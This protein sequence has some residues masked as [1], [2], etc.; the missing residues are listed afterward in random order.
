MVKLISRAKYISI[1]IAVS[2]FSGLFTFLI[3]SLPGIYLNLTVIYILPVTIDVIFT[4]SLLFS[5]RKLKSK[6]KFKNII[7][8]FIMAYI[9]LESNA[10]IFSIHKIISLILLIPVDSVIMSIPIFSIFNIRKKHNDLEF[11][12]DLTSRLSYL[13]GNNAPEVYTKENLTHGFGGII[14]EN[15][16]K[17][18]VHKN[19]LDALNEKE[20]DALLLELYYKKATKMSDKIVLFTFSF[21]AFLF[22]LYISSF[23]VSMNVS[24]IYFPYLIGITIGSLILLFI[25]PVFILKIISKGYISV[26]KEILLHNIDKN[27]LISLI[28]KENN[29]EPYTAMT[30]GQYNRFKE[31]QKKNAKRRIENID[32]V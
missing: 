6:N 5:M 28:N 9:L 3:F 30:P 19:A 24:S 31:K 20:L 21:I 11:N 18:V 32:K 2:L 17:I 29:Y 8:I 25:S 13:I 26:D 10:M 12:A 4:L 14:N 23:I 15:P 27:D 7:I 1:G 16:W 22:D